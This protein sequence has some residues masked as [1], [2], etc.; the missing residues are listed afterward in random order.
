MSSAATLCKHRNNQKSP[1]NP[2][3]INSEL[4]GKANTATNPK[5]S[6]RNNHLIKNHPPLSNPLEIHIR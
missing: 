6:N 5:I 1:Q 2:F 4:K 3:R